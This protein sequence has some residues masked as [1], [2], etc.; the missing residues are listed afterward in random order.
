[1]PVSIDPVKLKPL[2]GMEPGLYLTILYIAIFLIVLFLVAFLPGILHSGK[3]VTFTSAVEPTVVTVD[4]TYIGS[5]PITAFIEP[6][7]HE[8]TFSYEGV[9][10]VTQT[11]TVGHPVFLTWLFPRKQEVVSKTFINDISAF[12]NYLNSMFGHVVAWSAVTDFDEIYHRPPLFRQVAGTAASMAL[13]DGDTVLFEFLM[14]SLNHMTSSAMLSDFEEG[15]AIIEEHSILGES[16]I[17]TIARYVKMIEPLFDGDGSSNRIGLAPTD[18]VVTMERVSL[19][20]P[21]DGV[22]PLT[23]YSYGQQELVVGKQVPSTY[24]G[25]QEAGTD[26]MVQ[27]FTIGALEISEYLWAHF[28]AGNPYWAKSNSEQ[29]IADGMVDAMYLAGVYPT[30]SII[31]KQPI[32]NISWHA[33]AAFTEWLGEISGKRVFLPTNAQWEAAAR[34]VAGKDYQRGTIA[35]VERDGPSSMMGGYWEFT[36]D[37]YL[38]LGR[39]TGI[40]S[41]W[42]TPS[43][44][45]VVKGGSYLNDP[46]MVDRSSMGVMA[47]YEC[48]ETT[49]FRIAWID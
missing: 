26:T 47:R 38:P 17:G 37:S 9:G 3:R 19:E 1:M 36:A 27:P 43:A 12:R 48:S 42:E 23:G 13:Q 49:G 34:S 25:V 45:I 31:S 28:I 15:L 24:P 4:G 14:Q 18:A 20:I 29:L 5:T 10:S 2:F 41:R 32:R 6:G 21:I 46:T 8:A 33:A 35:V 7:I 22:Q 16:Q 30:T 11:F 39:F 44:D 40:E